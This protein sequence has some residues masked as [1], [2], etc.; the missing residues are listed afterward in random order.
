[1]LNLN[2]S[3]QIN[4]LPS[5]ST[6]PANTQVA[7]NT[8]NAT[9]FS[10]IMDQEISK[11]ANIGQLNNGT[12]GEA[13]VAETAQSPLLTNN[14]TSNSQPS[15][16]SQLQVATLGLITDD[17]NIE[18]PELKTQVPP[19]VLG[20]FSITQGIYTAKSID[21]P[22]VNTQTQAPNTLLVAANHKIEPSPLQLTSIQQNFSANLSGQTNSS[23]NFAA[24]SKIMPPTADTINNEALSIFEKS[25]VTLTTN[26]ILAAEPNNTLNTCTYHIVNLHIA[27]CS[28][29]S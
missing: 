9:T 23:A 3:P 4:N 26:T 19:N 28:F 29:N 7:S 22:I 20:K 6:G 10:E 13:H 24:F 15:L 16:A 25:A 21:Q 11:E 17:A 18:T 8:S 5:N 14:N 2:I 1:M 27:K 12:S